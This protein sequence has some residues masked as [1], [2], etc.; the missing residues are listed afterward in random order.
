MNSVYRST[1]SHGERMLADRAE[2]LAFKMLAKQYQSCS[3]SSNAPFS[4]GTPGERIALP[5]RYSAHSLPRSRRSREPGS[6]T[7]KTCRLPSPNSSSWL[8]R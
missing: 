8:R 3:S 6:T 5:A 1:I 4:T 7:L 2:L